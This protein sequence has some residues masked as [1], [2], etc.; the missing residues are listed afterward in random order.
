MKIVAKYNTL[1]GISTALTFGT[2]IITLFACGEAI[3][4]RSETALSA[5]AMFS[6]LLALFFLKDKLLEYF[7]A[8][9]ALIIS[10]V[11]LILIL[12]I[13]NIILPTKTICIATMIAC[14]VD[15]VTFKTWYKSIEVKLPE[16]SKQYKRVGF[17]FTTTKHI[18]ENNNE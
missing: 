6:L 15:E 1:K 12:M 3:V 4:H 11:A 10:S 17:I 5:A 18:M 2:P 8:P 9:S 7:K 16:I 14:G 13:E